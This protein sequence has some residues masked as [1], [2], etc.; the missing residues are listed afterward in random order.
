[1]DEQTQND[2]GAEFDG[3]LWDISR[4]LRTG[5]VGRIDPQ[6]YITL[7]DRAKDVIKSGGEWI[8]SVAIENALMSH[9]AVLEA[10]VVPHA[11]EEG[12]LK[13]K[14]FVVLKPGVSADDLDVSLKDHVKANVGMWKYPRW[15]EVRETLPKTATGKIQRFKLR[16]EA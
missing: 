13:P 2:Q 6:G 10:A 9:P 14:A 7:T 4:L 11:D 3:R 8:S 16:D 5:D 15:V 1:M 12:L